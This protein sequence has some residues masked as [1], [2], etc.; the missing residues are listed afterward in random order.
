MDPGRARDRD[1]QVG[2]VVV[3]ADGRAARRNEARTE[4]HEQPGRFG[5]DR[6]A[7]TDEAIESFRLHRG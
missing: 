1:A 6:E 2:R 7:A 4:P 3:T 5:V